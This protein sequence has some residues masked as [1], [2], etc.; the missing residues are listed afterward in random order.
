MSIIQAVI[1]LAN[2][3]GNFQCRIGLQTADVSLDDLNNPVNMTSTPMATQ[4]GTEGSRT[5]LRWDPNATGDGNIDAAAY[6]RVGVLYSLSSAGVPG[7]G[8]VELQGLCW[9]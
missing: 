4:V 7:Q 8:D 9:R 2:K 6:F 1:V 3:S 5:L